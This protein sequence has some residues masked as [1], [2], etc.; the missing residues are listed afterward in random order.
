MPFGIKDID[1]ELVTLLNDDEATPIGMIG[2]KMCP[3]LE[4]EDGT[5][6]GESMD[7]VAYLDALDGDP[8]F[9]QS[10]NREDLAGWISDTGV[11]Y[12]QLLFPRWV[13]APLEEFATEG[14][15]AYFTAK[16][17]NSIGPFDE[18]L[19]NTAT[20]KA[21]YEAALRLLE[22][23][24][25]T[26]QAVNGELS[27]DDIDMFGRLRGITLIKDLDIPAGVRAYIDYF[28][29]ASGVPLYDDVAR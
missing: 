5:F 7:I 26:P 4:R 9:A 16:K 21:E 17:E 23:M 25:A 24:I 10:A 6:M 1:F 18:A 28:A 2:A 20:Y 27:Y 12:R 15:R 14:A 29:E 11:L 3:I 22:P 19:A 13:A 8:V